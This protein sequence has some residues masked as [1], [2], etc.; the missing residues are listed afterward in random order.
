LPG[1]T[2]TLALSLAIGEERDAWLGPAGR[3]ARLNLAHGRGLQ[4][5]VG[6]GV[7]VGADVEEVRK[8]VLRRHD[9]AKR[10]P[11]DSPDP[12]LNP[13]RRGHDR[14]RISGGRPA[15]HASLFAQSGT[16]AD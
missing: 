2:G 8:A 15:R 12:A 5:V 14:T 4:Q 16:H 3:R 6:L 1:Q 7:D 9:G 11:L 13:E 10:G